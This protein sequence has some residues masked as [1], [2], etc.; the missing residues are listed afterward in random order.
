VAAGDVAAVERVLGPQLPRRLQVVES[1]YSARQ[2]DEVRDTFDA[3][4]A[5]WGFE[6][7]SCAGLTAG[8]QPYA[9]AWL[10]RLAPDLADWADSLPNGLLT[11]H[12]AMTPR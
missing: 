5:D 9:E 10:T 11:L 8:C 3:H 1:R 6:M 12:P 2:L 7:W 4:Y